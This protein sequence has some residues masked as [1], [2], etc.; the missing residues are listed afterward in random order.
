MNAFILTFD[1]I[2]HVMKA[3]KLLLAEKIKLEVIPTP[4]DISPNCGVSIRIHEENF[5]D[6]KITAI[7]QTGKLH[8]KISEKKYT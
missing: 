2:H 5:C 6:K 1:S 8:Y 7:L 4:Q 3:E